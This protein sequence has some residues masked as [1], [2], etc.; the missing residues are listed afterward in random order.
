MPSYMPS[1]ACDDPTGDRGRGSDSRVERTSTLSESTLSSAPTMSD[2]DDGISHHDGL[3]GIRSCSSSW[4]SLFLEEEAEELPP[5]TAQHEEEG[6]RAS[7]P[8]LPPIRGDCVS[9]EARKFSIASFLMPLLLRSTLSFLFSSATLR[10]TTWIS[11][12]ASM[13][14][15]S[16]SLR[17]CSSSWTYSLRRALERLWFSLIRARFDFSCGWVCLC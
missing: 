14:C 2:V 3:R 6:V 5:P 11:A 1:E 17:R 4:T 12:E 10:A 7:G 15:I 16:T 13:P 9:P 8:T